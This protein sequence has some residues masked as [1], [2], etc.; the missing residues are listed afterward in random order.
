MAVKVLNSRADLVYVALHFDLMQALS[1][2]QKF[3]ERLVLA[4]FKQD[5]Y[6]FS[7]LKEMLEAHNMIVMQTTVDLD[8]RHQLLLCA[9]FGERCLCDD[10]GG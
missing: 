6:I 3:I 10:L 4:Q 1:T 8:L 5:V 2:S 9:R 7:V